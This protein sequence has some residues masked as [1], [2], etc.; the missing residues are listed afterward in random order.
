MTAPAGAEEHRQD[1]YVEHAVGTE[2]KPHHLADMRIEGHAQESE[3][4]QHEQPEPGLLEHELAILGERIGERIEPRPARRELLRELPGRRCAGGGRGVVEQIVQALLGPRPAGLGRRQRRGLGIE[5]AR[6]ADQHAERF[7]G[8]EPAPFRLGQTGPNV[9]AADETPPE[10]PE[11]VAPRVRHNRPAPG[12]HFDLRGRRSSLFPWR[13]H[14]DDRPDLGAVE[15]RA[16]GTAD[17]E[18]DPVALELD[19]LGGAAGCAG[20]LVT[21]PDRDQDVAVLGDEQTDR[22]ILLRTSGAVGAHGIQRIPRRERHHRRRDGLRQKGIELGH[23]AGL[24]PG[25]EVAAIFLERQRQRC[26]E[27]QSLRQRDARRQPVSA[28]GQRRQQDDRRFAVRTEIVAPQGG[29]D[30]RDLR[31]ELRHILVAQ[32]AVPG[33][34]DHQRQAVRQ[35]LHTDHSGAFQDRD[36]SV[37][38]DR[39]ESWSSFVHHYRNGVN[40]IRFRRD[41][42]QLESTGIVRPQQRGGFQARAAGLAPTY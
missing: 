2:Q 12:R 6:E 23:V 3:E 41:A 19:H 26:D 16:R 5:L 11:R 13:H 28:L 9:G 30:G 20:A 14:M 21:I 29:E 15:A 31:L 33:H 37:K 17:V 36:G 7:P 34:P 35:R 40:N 24:E 1:Q 22:A 42:G 8:V 4:C 38:P 18:R 25:L 39:S 32:I 10:P 27:P